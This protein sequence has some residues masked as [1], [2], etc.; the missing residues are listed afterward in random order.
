MYDRGRT[1]DVLK[2]LKAQEN[3]PV[4]EVYKK[5]V[6]TQE[7]IPVKIINFPQKKIESLMQKIEE[8]RKKMKSGNEGYFNLYYDLRN[9]EQDFLKEAKILKEKNFNIPGITMKRV[10]MMLNS[11]KQAGEK[12]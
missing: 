1:I 2:K 7:E 9:A 8:I 12:K 4:P 10:D 11:I 3:K 5:P 6:R